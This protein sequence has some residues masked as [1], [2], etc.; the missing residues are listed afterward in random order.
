MRSLVRRFPALLAISAGVL[1]GC[2]G[3]D[4]CCAPL[5]QTTVAKPISLSGDAQ[6]AVVGQQLAEPIRVVVTEDGNPAVG[7]PVQWAATA[8]G[9]SVGPA[10]IVTD[11]NGIASTQWTLGPSIGNQTAQA[12]VS[13]AVGSP[14][15]FTATALAPP[16]PTAVGVAVL[17]NVFTSDRNATSNPA[18]D[19][20]AVGGSVT[21]TWA[22]TAN[23][24]HDVTST[25][26]PSFT[27][28]ATAIRPP[29]YTVTFTAAGDY[30][31]YCTLHGLPGS[32][33]TGRIVVR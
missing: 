33:M 12:S 26:S 7:I 10:S 13:E 30:S 27:S 1:S 8:G 18:V 5:V 16:L 24:P 29:P 4:E 9:G 20:V 11:A 15:T 14:V 31:Y 19:T 2:G 25:G 17:D 3:E 6:T 21:W 23:S 22:P 32:G 28:S